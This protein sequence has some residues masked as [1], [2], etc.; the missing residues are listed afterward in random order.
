M[1]NFF[2]KKTSLS[3]LK[4]LVFLLYRKIRPIEQK[5]LRAGCA[6]IGMEDALRAQF[7]AAKRAST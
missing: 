6:Q 5:A 4:R 7:G 1:S 2:D 3:C